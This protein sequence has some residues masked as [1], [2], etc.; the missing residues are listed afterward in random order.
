VASSKQTD[1]QCAGGCGEE[2]CGVIGPLLRP[3][4]R[5]ILR[6]PPG[7]ASN[8]V[9]C[10]SRHDALTLHSSTAALAVD[11]TP[12]ASYQKLELLRAPPSREFISPESRFWRKFRDPIVADLGSKVTHISF[13]PVAPHLFAVSSSSRVTIHDGDSCEVKKTLTRFRAEAYSAHF[14]SDGKLL[15]AGGE[16]PVVQVCNEFL[17]VIYI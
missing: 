17:R 10:A 6:G 9:R 5:L 2:F 12:M 14:R 4:S 15:V 7:P 8:S 11:N 3:A 1:W 16:E 13:S